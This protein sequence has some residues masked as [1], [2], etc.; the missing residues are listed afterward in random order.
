[1]PAGRSAEYIPKL[2]IVF[3]KKPM[4]DQWRIVKIVVLSLGV[5]LMVLL[6][7][8]KKLAGIL[9]EQ[10]GISEKE[11]FTPDWTYI[12]TVSRQIKNMSRFVPWTSNCLVQATVGKIL[13]RKKKIRSTVSF[14]VKKEGGKMEAHAWLT[15]YHKIVIGGEIADQFVEVSSFS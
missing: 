3:F 12:D 6:F 13:L 7:P 10:N 2:V 11:D 15:V 4:A 9:G 1:M 5:R 14:G 8:F